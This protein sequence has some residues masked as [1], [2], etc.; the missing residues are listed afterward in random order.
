M[1]W[2]Y[3]L[4]LFAPNLFG[5]VRLEG[6]VIDAKRGLPIPHVVIRDSLNRTIEAI[7][8]PN[9][10]F[11]IDISKMGTKTPT[12]NLQQNAVQIEAE[13]GRR[14]TKILTLIA[15]HDN[16]QTQ[17][18]PIDKSHLNAPLVIALQWQVQDQLEV[19]L[20]SGISEYDEFV[21]PGI[22]SGPLNAYGDPLTQAEQFDFGA[23]FYSPLG[24][25]RH[26]RGLFFQ[27]MNLRDPVN[28]SIQWNM[29]TGLNQAMRYRKN[30]NQ[31]DPENE[32]FGQVGGVTY[33]GVRPD[34]FNP[35][36]RIKTQW[37]N[38]SYQWGYSLQQVLP[39]QNGWSAL[40]LVSARDGL[41][42]LTQGNSYKAWGGLISIE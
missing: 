11:R 30:K 17:V 6:R 4:L 8:E 27:G 3:I 7:S 18:I 2:I 37:A 29:L 36:T 33:V 16:Y 5:Q 12:E 40:G 13:I 26:Q 42:G 22:I 28:G 21:D 9:G 20:S 25:G 24:A 41:S 39:K 34:E 31:F 38:R 35:G 10:L 23:V 1:R 19:D 14:G 32:G 15:E